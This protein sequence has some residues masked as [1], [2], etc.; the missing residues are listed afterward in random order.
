MWG[1]NTTWAHVFAAQSLCTDATVHFWH[2]SASGPSIPSLA[3]SADQSAVLL[4]KHIHLE[5]PS[6]LS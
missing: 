4:Y 3:H 5:N 1:E 6:S 2:V